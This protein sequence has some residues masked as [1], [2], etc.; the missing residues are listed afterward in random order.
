MSYTD[1]AQYYDALT[2]NAGYEERAEY[3]CALLRRYHH[4]WGETLDL[5]CGTGSLTLEFKKRGIDIYGVDGST[6]ML[7][8]AQA[9]AA[10]AGEQILFLHQQMQ[11]LDLYGCADTVFCTLDSLNHLLT[12]RD[13]FAA[14]ERVSLFLSPDGLFVFDM[15]TPYKHREVLG[16]NTFVY[17][18]DAVYCVWQNRYLPAGH[19]VD[20]TLDFFSRTG[21]LYQRSGE[22]FF[23]RAYEDAH[24]RRLL[25]Q[26]GLEVVG[27]FAEQSFQ[28]PVA[29]TQRVVYV[30]RKFSER[31]S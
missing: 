31:K 25:Q 9:K 4:P 22:H 19:R 12:Q 13:L 23:E 24:V 17:D 14:F 6:E 5:A 16:N 15:N 26:A 21:K 18:T 1:F 3:L 7:A 8:Q 20:I 11:K 30:A 28:R 27:F 2:Q 29:D 10:Q